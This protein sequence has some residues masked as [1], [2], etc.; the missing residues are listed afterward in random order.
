MGVYFSELLS[1][2]ETCGV[3]PNALQTSC[4]S[5]TTATTEYL[6]NILSFSEQ[7][8]KAE[9]TPLPLCFS[10]N[11]SSADNLQSY[12]H[13]GSCS[14]LTATERSGQSSRCMRL[15]PKSLSSALIH[16]VS[17]GSST[18]TPVMEQQGSF[19]L[20]CSYQGY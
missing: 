12:F 18:G 13:S 3:I 11:F 9:K 4:N 19:H 20:S 8:A 7:S 17:T 14:T 2:S 15:Q 10:D 5:L 16:Q 1:Q 6:F